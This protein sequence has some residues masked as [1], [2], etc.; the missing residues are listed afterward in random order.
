MA[1][2]AETEKIQQSLVQRQTLEKSLAALSEERMN[3]CTFVQQTEGVRST[4]LRA[5]SSFTLGLEARTQMLSEAL[6]RIDKQIEEQRARLLKAQQDERSVRKLKSKR[7][8]EWNLRAEHEIETT[9]QELWLLSHT[10]N[11][12]G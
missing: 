2:E 10:R 6:R 8:A 5:L 9:A 3:A 12:E 1:V 4:D 7:L 11:T